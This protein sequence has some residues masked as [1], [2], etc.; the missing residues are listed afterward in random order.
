MPIAPL[1]AGGEQERGLRG[2]TSNV[3]GAVGFARALS[4]AQ[5]E[6]EAYIRHTGSLRDAFEQRILAE[7]GSEVRADG[8]RRKQALLDQLRAKA[9]SEI[10]GKAVVKVTDYLV[11]ETGTPKADVLRYNMEDGSQLI[12]RPS[13]TEPLIKCYVTLCGTRQSN[14]KQNESV[15]KYLDRVFG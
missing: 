4:L 1:I 3:A 7:L 10:D 14:E 8:A 12:V 5:A 13:G 9:P 11:D 15:K 6:R 2:G